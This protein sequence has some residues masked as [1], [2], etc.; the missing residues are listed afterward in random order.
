MAVTRE[1]VFTYNQYYID[2]G[3]PTVPNEEIYDTMMTFERPIYVD[4]PTGFNDAEPAKFMIIFDGEFCVWDVD[5]RSDSWFGNAAQ[6][7]L[8]CVAGGAAPESPVSVMRYYEY[9]YPSAYEHNWHAEFIFDQVLPAVTEDP[10]IS[11][12]YPNLRFSEVTCSF[13]DFARE[14]LDTITLFEHSK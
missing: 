7:V 10:A 5:F 2:N 6:T 11:E 13:D 8:V 1:A 12:R 3:Y 4:I 14:A 9:D